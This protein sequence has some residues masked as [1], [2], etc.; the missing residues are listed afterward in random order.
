M[1]YRSGWRTRLACWLRRLGATNFQ[2]VS[3]LLY[4]YGHL[5][6]HADE[7]VAESFPM[8]DLTRFKRELEIELSSENCF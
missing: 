8:K 4:V 2:D 5:F 7:S 1:H 3:A 6:N